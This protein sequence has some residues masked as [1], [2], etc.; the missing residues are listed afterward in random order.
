MLNAGCCADNKGL[1]DRC[2]GENSEN[3]AENARVAR[4]D[5]QTHSQ[6]YCVQTIF[7]CAVLAAARLGHDDKFAGRVCF[8]VCY[9]SRRGRLGRG[10]RLNV[11][12]VAPRDVLLRRSR[13]EVVAEAHERVVANSAYRRGR[14]VCRDGSGHGLCSRGFGNACKKLLP[15]REIVYIVAGRERHEGYQNML[16]YVDSHAFASAEHHVTHSWRAGEEN[17]GTASAV[18]QS[19]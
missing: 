3:D 15:P 10:R 13:C 14:S 2:G 12:R 19:L 11:V 1:A 17:R 18:A 9:R 8:H 6:R 5:E 4:S 7:S 16:P